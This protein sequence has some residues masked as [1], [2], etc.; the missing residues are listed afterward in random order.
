MSFQPRSASHSWWN[1]LCVV[2]SASI[3]L[4][5]VLF[6][7]S[8][9]SGASLPTPDRSALAALPTAT[10]T[11]PTPSLAVAL[12]RRPTDTATP[13]PTA[14]PTATPTGTATPTA[15][16]T[17]TATPT[18]TPGPLFTALGFLDDTL[19]K[20]EEAGYRVT[21]QQATGPASDQ[22]I[23]Y[24]VE[25]PKDDNGVIV[26]D[27]VP[28][29]LIYRRRAGQPAQLLFQD[30]GSDE[31]IQFAGLGYAWDEPLGWQDLNGDG[32]LELP[33]WAANGGYC[34]ACNRVYILQLRPQTNTQAA[35]RAG[36]SE[37][38]AGTRLRPRAYQI[39][40][41][42]GAVP[43]LNLLTKPFIPKW[44]NDLDG[45]GRPEIEVLDG[46]F[47]FGFGLDR[48]WSPGLYRVYD[49]DG[50]A[51][52]DVSLYYPGYFD[53]QI[54]KARSAVEA[55]YGQPLQGQPEIGRSLLVLLAYTAR[56]Q[57]DEG[58]N[59][60][61]QLSDPT[62]WAGEATPGAL[63][64]LNQ[65]RDYLRG[66]YEAG[67][68]FHSWPPSPPSPRSFEPSEQQPAAPPAE[69]A[70]P[71]AESAPPPTNEP[72]PT[73]QEAT[74]TPQATAPSEATATPAEPTATP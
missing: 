15:S 34:W 41:L 67:E 74:P 71:P 17:P 30:E 24:L 29:L 13:L 20:L 33:I 58:W 72:P 50:S 61:W 45:D 22:V 38:G 39:R 43:H 59:V 69:P 1:R 40:E 55:A 42:T 26:G 8:A 52:S 23:A 5:S 62:H 46:T 32:L 31:S 14:T 48:Q 19:T 60:F 47:E 49:W 11:E 9:C 12:P 18:A 25:P 66:Q 44:L 53:F 6:S 3:L 16:P 64:W 56:G 73:P 35:G 4:I 51:Y 36:E 65:V 68:P 21:D 7:L 57:R 28:R 27:A 54:D 63:A 70:T 2:G 10:P 37:P